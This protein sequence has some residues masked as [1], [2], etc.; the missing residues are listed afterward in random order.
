MLSPGASEAS[1]KSVSL[2]QNPLAFAMHFYVPGRAPQHK[3][4]L[5]SK[6]NLSP[7]EETLKDT[8]DAVTIGLR[9]EHL[10]TLERV[11]RDYG[12]MDRS[13]FF[14]LCTDALIKAHGDGRHRL[15]WLPRF[16]LRD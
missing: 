6:T 11:V 7:A 3:S 4:V 10:G 8:A 12:F 5:L 14:Q 1:E 13:H 9:L 16:V 15:D 2:H